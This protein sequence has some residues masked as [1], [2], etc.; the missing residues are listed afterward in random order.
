MTEK[1]DA[2]MTKCAELIR[3]TEEA[4]DGPHLKSLLSCV[5]GRNIDSEIL[6]GFY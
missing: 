1:S 5:W 3:M 4:L 6:W 2:A